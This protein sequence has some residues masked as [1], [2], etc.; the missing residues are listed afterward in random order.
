MSSVLL[1]PLFTALLVMCSKSLKTTFPNLK[2]PCRISLRSCA[3]F[4]LWRASIESRLG[5]GWCYK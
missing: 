3:W 4:A 2:F 5:T 1:L